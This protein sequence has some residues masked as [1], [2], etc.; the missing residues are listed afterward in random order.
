MSSLFFGCSFFNSVDCRLLILK[1]ITLNSLLSLRPYFIRY[2]W[3]LLMGVVFV[4]LANYF[5]ILQPQAI[6]DALNLV[7]EQLDSKNDIATSIELLKYDLL[8]FAGLVL[9]YALLMG[10]FMFFMRQT[11]IVTSRLMEYDMRKDI[12]AHYQT[13]DLGFFRRNKT[14]DLMARITED[15]SKVRM[16]TGPAI[17]YAINIVFLFT[18]V[19]SS[20]FSVN[21][22]L[23]IYSLLPLPIL[24]I[25]I[26]FV[27]N[28]INRRS[29]RIQKQ[30]SVLHSLAQ[31]VFSGIRIVKSYVKEEQVGAVFKKE[32]LAYKE[33]SMRLASVE[34]LFTPLMLLI[35]GTS[36]IL[37]IYFGG[38]QVMEGT[39]QAGNV[40]EFVIYVNML[41][42]PVTSMGWIASLVQQAAVSQ[43]RID[44]F[45]HIC[46]EIKPQGQK[47]VAI[48]GAIRFEGVNFTY[49]D[50]GIKALSQVQFEIGAG[51]R[52]AILGHA[53]SGKTTI[54]DLLVRMYEPEQGKIFIDNI[55]LADFQLE[56]LRERIGYVP[57]D[58]FLF[59]ENVRDNI[60][61]GDKHFNQSQIESVARFASVHEDIKGFS[62]GYETVVGERGVMLSG[63]QK[64]RISLARTLI[65]DPNILILDDCLSAV[66]THTEQMILEYL[67]TVLKG[68]TAIIITHRIYESLHFDKIIVLDHGNIIEFGTHHELIE[69]KGYYYRMLERQRLQIDEN[70]AM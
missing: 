30:L 32:T 36:T 41:T 16:Y 53:G 1:K 46:P 69:R 50:T 27:S 12:Y 49:P 28:I 29:E 62:E 34:S 51:E 54:A 25:S 70:K 56:Y 67:D 11:I 17:M 22:E 38:R 52:V 13:L 60:A 21:T 57:Q 18:F 2:K 14:G 10:V 37:T 31:E 6:R 42:W 9:G 65:K 44:E 20:M 24:S 8:K 63:G 33:K 55:P 4:C 43:R 19:I 7:V 47:K 45:M 48:K 3:R 39:L 58:V 35:I 64:Q 59:S 26:Y 61:F 68:K 23:A 40:A 66:D 5:Q 15:V